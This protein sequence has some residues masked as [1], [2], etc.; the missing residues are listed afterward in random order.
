MHQ[1]MN[2]PYRDQ[3]QQ[4]QMAMRIEESKG[5]EFFAWMQENWIGAVDQPNHTLTNG[6][7]GEYRLVDHPNNE[8]W[9]THT[10]PLLSD[11]NE[12]E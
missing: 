12:R 4:L 5:D 7:L 11:N 1:Y 2:S 3:L 8:V 10:S 6:D 9:L